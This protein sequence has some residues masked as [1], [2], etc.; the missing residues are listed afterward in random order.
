[1]HSSE[2][3]ITSLSKEEQRQEFSDGSG[4][5]W[6]D[7]GARMYDQQIC[8]FQ[9]Q[10]PLSVKI[11]DWNP[12]SFS[13]DNPVN[14]ID[15][16]GLEP[17]EQDRDYDYYRDS[18]YDSDPPVK[19]L[20]EVFIYLYFKRGERENGEETENDFSRDYEFGFIHNFDFDFDDISDLLSDIW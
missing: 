3:Q 11:P 2:A 12:Y 15:P 17:Y 19:T 20:Q 1:M 6:L 10:D 9:S 14:F 4:L 8:K 13:F 5:E 18:D 16:M 7:F